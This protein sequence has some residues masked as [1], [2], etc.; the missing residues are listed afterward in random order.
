MSQ[1]PNIIDV[2]ENSFDK[3]VIEQSQQVPVLVD[4]WAPWCGPCRTLGPA[5]EKLANDNSL[6]FVLAKVNVDENP[7]LSVR[8]GIQGIPAVKAFYGGQIVSE[9]VGVRSEPQLRQFIAQIQ[10]P[11]E[12]HLLN[13]GRSLL[14]TRHWQDAENAFRDMLDEYPE[15]SKAA[16]GLAKALLAQGEGGEAL[17]NLAFVTD[18]K[19]LRS[20]E[21]LR[22]LATF[23]DRYADYWDDDDDVGDLERQYRQA[24]VLFNRGNLAASMDGVLDV[25]RQDKRF[26]KGEARQVM[27]AI[28]EI[29]GEDDELTQQ[30]RREL[31]TVLF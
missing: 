27:I 16:L 1:N 11:Q 15:D 10:P 7:A 14:A 30:Y 8:Y 18:G 17:D 25:L 23:L 2:T 4:F 9:F 6:A 20:A 26:R 24:A 28:F 12:N 22:P 19:E 21:T 5:L 29:L 3:D 13:E 31:A